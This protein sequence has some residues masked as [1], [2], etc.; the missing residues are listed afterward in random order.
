MNASAP[1]RRLHPRRP[2]QSVFAHVVSGR[3]SASCEIINLSLGGLLART[4]EPWIATERLSVTL[5][6]PG[7][8]QVLR[9]EGRQVG[10]KAGTAASSVRLA[11]DAVSEEALH[12][13]EEVLRSAPTQTVRAPPQE[14]AGLDREAL[15]GR[16]ALLEDQLRTAEQAR[17]AAELTVERL[18]TQL[19]VRP[20]A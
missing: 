9:L 18:C 11:F 20:R 1:E 2:A 6:R 4:R 19:A 17:L 10:V 15:L 14:A 5:A 3:H 8:R 7:W 12:L 16:I 13:L